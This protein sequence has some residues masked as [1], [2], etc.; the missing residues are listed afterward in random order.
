MADKST[1]T[2]NITAS[3]AEEIAG[4]VEDGWAKVYEDGL[5]FYSDENY[6]TK[7]SSLSGDIVVVGMK[8]ANASS[9]YFGS[10][11]LYNNR[12]LTKFKNTFITSA[13]FD[14]L[15]G[16]TFKHLKETSK[17]VLFQLYLR[18]TI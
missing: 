2:Y 6:T 5:S 15:S 18:T 17:Q 1:K 9:T 10:G 16:C 13:G 11:A 8:N 14:L 4:M 3:A 7:L 12:N